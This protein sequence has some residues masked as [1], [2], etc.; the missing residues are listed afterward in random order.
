MRY[1]RPKYIIGAKRTK[2]KF[3]WFPKW[4]KGDYRWLENATWE[5]EYYDVYYHDGPFCG[6]MWIAR[7]WIDAK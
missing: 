5:D 4:I 6:G 7:R 1:K 2:S 3:L